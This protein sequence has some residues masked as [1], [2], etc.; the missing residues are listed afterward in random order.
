MREA[1]IEI[2]DGPRFVCARRWPRA[3]LRAPGWIPA[4]VN[5][6]ANPAHDAIKFAVEDDTMEPGWMEFERGRLA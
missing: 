1:K 3:G 6:W 2:D 5:V 4:D